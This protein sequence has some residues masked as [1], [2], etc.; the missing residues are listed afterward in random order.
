MRKS[1]K[2]ASVFTALGLLL[3]VGSVS[4]ATV[5][6]CQNLQ[7]MNL[8]L[9]GDYELSNDID[10][11]DTATW[12]PDGGGGYYGFDPI[13]TNSTDPFTGTLDGNNLTIDGLFINRPTTSGVGLFGYTDLSS[14]INNVGLINVNVTGNTTVGSLAGENNGN[15]SES[16]V[17]GNI[18]LSNDLVYP[19][20]TFFNT[21][22]T[23]FG[24]ATALDFFGDATLFGYPNGLT[25][26]GNSSG[27]TNEDLIQNLEFRFTGNASNDDSLVTSG[28]QMATIYDA[29][30]A[31]PTRI[32]AP[33]ELWEK[34]RNRQINYWIISRNADNDAP[35]GND[36][37]P[38]WYRMSG[39]D[40]IIPYP[41]DYNENATPSD[42][43]ITGNHSTW[44]LFFKQNG[45]SIWS[46]GDEFL[47]K[48]GNNIAGGL[49]G[50][51][52]GNISYSYSLGN[53]ISGEFAGGLVGLN[54]GEVIN[55]YAVGNV[56]GIEGGLIGFNSGIVNNSFYDNE[57]S[58]QN[59]FGKGL[60]LP[61]TQMMTQ[62][63]FTSAGWD[64]TTPVWKILTGSYPCLQWQPNGT[65]I[66]PGV[67]PPPPP[68]P[69]PAEERAVI[70]RG[71]S[72]KAIKRPS[73]MTDRKSVV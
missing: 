11:S 30:Q 52:S 28:G 15:I 36:G 58:G 62:S 23:V 35:W 48:Y 21:N 33:F 53:I 42:V 46:T 9:A 63:T 71:T 7:D 43:G 32:R 65:C 5:T 55:T 73:G 3:A 22:Q 18:S 13:G 68:P 27:T 34:E 16:Y 70:P 38:E 10:C 20:I 64:F 4:A 12:N 47:I 26:Y 69:P 31:N 66:F 59:D 45:A 60:G 50:L 54:S 6:T 56:A 61:T 37:V 51:N 29:T 41:T 57:I 8:D 49:V 17:S 2:I 67:A 24:G 39:R 14:T 72:G 1:F 19:P 25:F 40:Y 44:I